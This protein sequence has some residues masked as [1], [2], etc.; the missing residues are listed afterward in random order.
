M[1]FIYEAEEILEEY[2]SSYSEIDKE[3]LARRLEQ[4]A[5]NTAEEVYSAVLEFCPVHN[6]GSY[7]KFVD[8]LEEWL[9]HKYGLGV[10]G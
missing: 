4:I 9:K 1:S 5:K 8:L 10:E 7:S 2:A 6:D 3:K